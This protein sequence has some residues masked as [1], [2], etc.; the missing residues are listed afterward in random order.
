MDEMERAGDVRFDRKTALTGAAGALAA[1]VFL[2]DPALAR[3][4]LRQSET[5]RASNGGILR[6]G[7]VGNGPNE[8]LDPQNQQ[9]VIDTA[10]DRVLFDTLARQRANGTIEPRLALTFEPNKTADVGT[11]TLRPD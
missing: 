2:R 4:A 8:V 1:G 3:A 6:V 10:T 11:V 5:V 7:L 9:N